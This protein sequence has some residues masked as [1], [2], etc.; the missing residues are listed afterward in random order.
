MQI[1]FCR[2]TK[3][4][5]KWLHKVL[6]AEDRKKMKILLKIWTQISLLH[7]NLRIMI[8]IESVIFIF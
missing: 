6:T 3:N 1:A 2:V 4:T 5:K 8:L 7:L